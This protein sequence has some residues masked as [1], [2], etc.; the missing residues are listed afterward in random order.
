M[1]FNALVPEL[2][3][4]DFSKSIDFYVNLLGFTIE[5]QRVEEKFAYLSYGKS[6]MMINQDNGYWETGEMIYPRGRGINFQID[7]PNVV[8]IKS[9]VLENNIIIYRDIKEE[10]Y[11]VDEV[12]E[13]VKEILILDP[14]GY[15]L[16]FQEYIGQR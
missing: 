15:L 8:Q 2:L 4:S 12:E 5:F 3:I 10:W 16:R 6:Q 9:I 14:D 13:G 11:R 7:C 1:D